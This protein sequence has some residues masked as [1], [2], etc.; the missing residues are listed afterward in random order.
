[1]LIYTNT[2]ILFHVSM[3]GKKKV[4]LRMISSSTTTTTTTTKTTI[5]NYFLIT[6]Q[7]IRK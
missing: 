5:P 4:H 3:F 1:M 2:L 6:F 7:N